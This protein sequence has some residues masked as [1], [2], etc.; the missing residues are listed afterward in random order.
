MVLGLYYDFISAW[1]SGKNPSPINEAI[2]NKELMRV[3]GLSTELC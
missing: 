1:R 2:T 3:M